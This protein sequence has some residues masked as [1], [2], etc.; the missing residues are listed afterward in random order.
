MPLDKARHSQA[1]RD[2]RARYARTV[3]VAVRHAGQ[4]QGLDAGIDW[5]GISDP[6]K[7]SAPQAIHDRILNEG[8]GSSGEDRS[9]APD[10]RHRGPRRRAMGGYQK[11]LVAGTALAII[12][13]GMDN[14]LSAMSSGIDEEWSLPRG[15]FTTVL[16]LGPL[17]MIL[18]ARPAACSAIR[19]GRRTALVSASS[20]RGPD[21][22][23]CRGQRRGMLAS[24]AFSPASALAARC[25]CAALAA[26]YVPRVIVRS[27]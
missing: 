7:L 1:R 20:R 5:D 8:S 10:R 24:S 19:L 6:A 17:G 3:T 4:A 13:D 18:A 11:L 2:R 9:R 16:A 15:P 27:P 25:E 23:D 21:L 12:L 22:R 14:Q 26:E